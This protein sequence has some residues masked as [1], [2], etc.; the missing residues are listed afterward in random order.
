[1]SSDTGVV[2]LVVICGVIAGLIIYFLPTIIAKN[3]AMDGVAALFFVNLLLG[4]TLIGW[5]VVLLWAALGQT[6]AQK[7][8]FEQRAGQ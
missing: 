3:R 4:W 1:M 7:H 8:F 2:A 5:V 6:Q